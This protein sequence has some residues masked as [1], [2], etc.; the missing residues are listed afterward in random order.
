VANIESLQCSLVLVDRRSKPRDHHDDF[1]YLGLVLLLF[2]PAQ[3]NVLRAHFVENIYVSIN[4]I[5]DIAPWQSAG[6]KQQNSYQM[7]LHLLKVHDIAH[8]GIHT[9]IVVGFPIFADSVW[10]E[11]QLHVVGPW[12][13]QHDSI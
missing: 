6:E 2:S 3:V 8:V 11:V 5:Q 13:R 10:H 9:Q 1:R 7:S 4:P 12:R